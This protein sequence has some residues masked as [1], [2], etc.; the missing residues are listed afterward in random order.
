MEANE[1][2]HDALERDDPG[3]TGRSLDRL[4]S[5]GGAAGPAALIRAG[6]NGAVLVI[7]PGS[8]E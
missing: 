3:L 7:T 8:D 5:Q 4:W 1:H 2:E 6:R